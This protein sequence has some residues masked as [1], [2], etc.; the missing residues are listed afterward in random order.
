MMVVEI[1][2]TIEYSETNFNLLKAYV[3]I[4]RKNCKK[5]DCKVK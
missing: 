4:H 5:V 2:K 1:L 3:E